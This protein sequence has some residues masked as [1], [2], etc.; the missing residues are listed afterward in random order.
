M[1]SG[2][3]PLSRMSSMIHSPVSGPAPATAAVHAP[4][5]ALLVLGMHRSGTSAVTGALRLAGADLGT[6]L[7]AAGPDNP[8]GFWEHAGVVAIHERLL[9]AL[10]RAWNDP[11]PLPAGWLESAAARQAS[12]ELEALLRAEFSGTA[13]WAVKDPRM[14]R[15]LPLWWPIL[16]RMGVEPAAMFVLRH[17]DEVA[18]SLAARNQ[19]PEGLSRLLWIQHLLDAEQ[20]T[21]AVP[22]TVVAYPALLADAPTTLRAAFAAVSVGLPP[23]RG[24][25]EDALAGFISAGDRHHTA[26]AATD[27]DAELAQHMYDALQAARPWDALRPLRARYEDAQ[28]LFGTALDQCVALEARAHAALDDARQ[29]IDQAMPLLEERERV[30][31]E[32]GELK[33]D[34]RSLHD[35][36][37]RLQHEHED[38]TRWALEM[39][40]EITQWRHAVA[41]LGHVEDAPV[42]TASP[43]AA[44]QGIERLANRHADLRRSHGELDERMRMVLAS[45]SWKLTRPLRLAARIV[46]G[47][48][49][50]VVEALRASGLAR[51]RWLAPLRPLVRRWLAPRLD[52]ANAEPLARGAG[53]AARDIDVGDLAFPEFDA[54]QVSVII[55]AYGN[56]P[57]TAACLR[58]IMAHP[59]AASCEVIVAEDASGDAQ[60]GALAR[61]PGLRYHENPQNLGFLRSCNHAASLARGQFV[62]FL[63][64][65][66]EVTD[67]WLDAL[68][69]VFE[70]ADA[71]LVGS[72]LVYPDGRL[73]EAG[74]IVWADGSA[75][76]YGRLDDPRKSAYSYLKEA[77]YVSGAS[78]MLRSEV[79]A[80]LGGFDERYAPA[81]YEDT[82]IAFRVRELGLKVYMQPASV[83][84]HHEGISNGTDESGGI[85]SY[86]AVNRAKFLERWLPTLQAGHFANGEQ[87]FLARDRSRNRPHVLVVDH[88]VPQ[89]DRDAGSRATWHVIRMLVERGH[90]VT[91]WPDNLHRDPVYSP[92]LQQLGVEVIHGGEFRGRF[93]AWMAEHGRHLQAVVLNRPDV[94]VKYIDAVRRHS[95]ARVVYYGHDVHHL[96]LLEQ[97]RL[98]PDAKL[99]AEARRVG[100]LEHDLWR[101]SDVVL[102]PSTDETAHVQQWL[103][104]RGGGAQALTAPLF[105]YEPLAQEQVPGPGTRSGLLFVAGF[106]HPPNVDAVRWLMAE[107]LPLV[108]REFPQVRLSLVGSN[109]HPEVQAMA[110]DGVEV[111]GYV[112]DER[113]A[114]Y[115]RDARVVVAPLRFGGGVKGKVL[116]SL[117]FGVPCVT[118]PTGMQ[119]LGAAAGFMPSSADAA[120][121]AAMV[122]RLLRDDD[123]WCEVSQASRTFIDGHYSPQA[124]WN[125]LSAALVPA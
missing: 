87:V 58:S 97:V 48:W 104:T 45:R 86:Q 8:R 36:H 105:A 29:Q 59:S 22:R 95:R 79:F 21:R 92:P 18:A 4:S 11:R 124:L 40:A 90:Q 49:A 64:N 43:Q 31:V 55:P 50:G 33:H 35:A 30:L 28:R 46:R 32:L 117:R 5:R 65:D 115:Y 60:I 84:V 107:V 108:R 6:D 20:A 81:Y 111:T 54:P 3:D 66:T 82:D 109:P 51:S 102:Y 27:A 106:A 42:D 83:V 53:P 112:S 120:A 78:I 91:F 113:L 67:G 9:L 41:P 68:L 56:L 69:A 19:W 99:E 26:T 116:E 71:G 7:M 85:K 63:N 80:R 88:F 118:T 47:D 39:D 77:D 114:A 17:P 94:S 38:R 73:Q 74:G 34:H 70:R 62:L 44:A 13:L 125:V 110:G 1:A 121:F 72:K 25:L 123:H 98:Q 23:Q 57:Y 24:S 52:A 100:T 93:D 89:P 103:E 14:C 122:V 12:V 101:R 15:L 10:D 61:V 75:W 76:N 16:A 2:A 37:L 96:R 119:G